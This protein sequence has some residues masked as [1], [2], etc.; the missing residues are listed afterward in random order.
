[1]KKIAFSRRNFLKSTIVSAA[2]AGTSLSAHAGDIPEKW[3]QPKCSGWSWEQPVKPISADQI[4]KTVSTDVVVIGAGLAGF[5]AA[6]SALQQGAKVILIEKTKGWSCR[7]GH[8]T[9][10][11]TKLQQKMGV[12]INPEEIVRRLVA[13]GQGRMDERL[14]WMFAAKCGDC[15]DWLADIG[16]KYGV[17]QTL[18]EG[19]YKGPTYTEFPVTHFFYNKDVNLDYTYGNS[20]GIGNVVIMP[21]L[22]SEIKKAGGEIM[23]RTPAVQFVTDKDGA[24]TGVI[25]GRPGKLVQINAKNVIIASGCYAS[26]EEMRKAFAPYSL[27]ADAQIYFPTKSNTGDCHIMAMQVGGA[28]QKN[29]NHAATVHLEA[30]AGSYGFLHVN[31]LG[32]R[33]M[34][35]DVNTQSKSC[36]KELQPHGIAWTVYD[37]DWTDVVKKQ[38]DGNMAGGLFYG[39]MWQPWGNGWNVEVEKATQAQHIKDGK[40]FQANS[41]EELAQK[42]NVPADQLKATIDRYNELCAKGHDDDFGKRK[43]LMTPVLKAPFYAGRLVS[44]LLAMSGGLHTDPSLQVLDANDKPI[45]G[46]Y[47]CGAAAGDY[48]GSGDYPTICPGMNHGRAITFGRLAGIM[49]A[50]GD[51]DKV[52][53]TKLVG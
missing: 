30:G 37:A 29:D 28:M 4:G 51:I 12:K 35:E 21:C 45:K 40:V 48:F 47:V 17:Q 39:Q 20:T 5:S 34:N 2:A 44:S 33:F 10:F 52:V 53:K 14:L 19:Y 11:N 24:V 49:A 9:A 3:A 13:W 6:L 27:R 42:I 23:Y 22:E 18:W 43:E 26:N 1:M 46:L 50:G 41:I 32:K 38:V 25:A 15:Y 16:D 8:I 31:G 7:G 36:S